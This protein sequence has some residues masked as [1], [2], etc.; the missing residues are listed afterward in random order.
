MKL[1]GMWDGSTHRR[2]L[3]GQGSAVAGMLCALGNHV[4]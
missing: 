2:V 3:P 1:S 4:G